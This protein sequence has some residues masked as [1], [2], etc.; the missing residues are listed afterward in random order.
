MAG[1]RER[2]V[3]DGDRRR[4]SDRQGGAAYAL[5]GQRDRDPGE[6]D[7]EARRPGSRGSPESRA[8]RRSPAGPN[9]RRAGRRARTGPRAGTG[10]GPVS[11]QT[12]TAAANQSE[13]IRARAPNRGRAE[14]REQRRRARP[15]PGRRPGAARAGPKRRI[16]DAV[17][18]DGNG[19]STSRCS[20]SRSRGRRTGRRGRSRP[21]GPGSRAPRSGRQPPT[22]PR[23]ASARE[24]SSGAGRR[25]SWLS[26]TT[27][28][29]ERSTSAGRSTAC[30]R[31]SAT[32]PRTLP[33]AEGVELRC[34]VE[35]GRDVDA[36]ELRGGYD[37]V[38]L[39][40]GSRVPRLAGRRTRARRRAL[41]DDRL[42]LTSATARGGAR[43]RGRADRAA[44][45]DQPR[46]QREGPSTSS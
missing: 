31:Q 46:D 37:A 30:S 39:A 22:P 14:E 43:G 44:A 10:S 11:S 29:S 36:E 23:A 34:G 21:Q 9:R 4:P 16:E 35:V 33:I 17:G 32:S 40:T 5:A 1:D 20:R 24:R 13:G 8:G 18:E 6:G 3:E 41:R 42:L 15:P 25:P 19:P 38:V 7:E 27:W 12:P 26:F 2:E 28:R 45:V